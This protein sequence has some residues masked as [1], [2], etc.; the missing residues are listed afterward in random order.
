M[1]VCVCVCVYVCVCV[2]VCV[3]VIAL[4][5]LTDI[6]IIK[7]HCCFNKNLSNIITLKLLRVQIFADVSTG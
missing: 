3:C 4:L 1:C 6:V 5:L 7:S 2:C